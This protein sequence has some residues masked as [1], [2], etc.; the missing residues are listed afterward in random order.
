MT[1]LLRIPAHTRRK[2]EDPYADIKAAKTAQLRE[3]VALADL[4]RAIAALVARDV[5]RKVH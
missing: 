4:E 5:E 1:A 3:E 2:P